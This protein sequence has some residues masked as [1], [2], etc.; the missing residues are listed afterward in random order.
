MERFERVRHLKRK[1]VIEAVTL[2]LVEGALVVLSIREMQE[3]RLPILQVAIGFEAS[4]QAIYRGLRLK[5]ED[6][7]WR[8]SFNKLIGRRIVK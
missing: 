2:G 4:K 3:G 5:F 1:E 7:G 6:K 8:N